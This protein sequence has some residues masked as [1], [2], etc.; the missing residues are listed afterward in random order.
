MS[1]GQLA[2]CGSSSGLQ[3]AGGRARSAAERRTEAEDRDR[4]RPRAATDGTTAGRGDFCA[5]HRERVIGA[6]GA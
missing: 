2:A 5:R 4:A 3:H 1:S 6:R